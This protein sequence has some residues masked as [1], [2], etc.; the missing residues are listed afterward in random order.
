[1]GGEDRADTLSNGF[2]VVN[3]Q[4]AQTGHKYVK[5]DFGKRGG[6]PCRKN[7]RVSLSNVIARVNLYGPSGNSAVEIFWGGESLIGAVVRY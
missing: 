1:M 4:N 3:Y 5:S 7:R 6:R 2:V